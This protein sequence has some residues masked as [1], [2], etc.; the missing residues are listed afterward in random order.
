MAI[1]NKNEIRLY[2][3]THNASP[4]EVAKIFDIPYRTLAHWI[5]AENWQKGAAL[6]S[7]N[8]K[9]I[10]NNLV[11]REFATIIDATHKN[12]KQEI[13]Q[14]LPS[15]FYDI[16]AIV[17]NNMLETSTDEILLKAMELNFIQKNIA[18]SAILAKDE[19]LK[20]TRLRKDD[21]PDPLFI[22]CAEKVAKLF[23]DMQSSIYGKEPLLRPADSQN[24]DLTKLSTQELLAMLGNEKE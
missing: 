2:F 19:L 14:N 13:K 12:I 16:D 15:Y 18:L 23:S 7:V 6:N 8:P 17:A 10:Q 4:K 22:A 1:K 11:S 20:M 21:K 5:K 24:V 9:T 3:E